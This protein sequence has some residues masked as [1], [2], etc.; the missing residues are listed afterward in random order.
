M[1]ELRLGDR[2]LYQSHACY[3]RGLD[4]TTGR[5]RLEDTVTRK[6]VE[7]EA[8]ELDREPPLSSHHRPAPGWELR[9]RRA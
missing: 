9:R 3:V 2:V 4:A 8:G 1:R 5:A 6:L 7:A